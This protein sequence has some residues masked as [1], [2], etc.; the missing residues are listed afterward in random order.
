M[1][2]V[3]RSH[4]DRCHSPGLAQETRVEAQELHPARYMLAIGHGL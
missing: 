4:F 2:R 1:D 3:Q